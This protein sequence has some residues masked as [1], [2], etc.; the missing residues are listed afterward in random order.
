M[1]KTKICTKCGIEKELS[2][3]YRRKKSIDGLCPYCKLCIKKERS[4]YH[5]KNKNKIKL[6]NK[7]YRENN[8]EKLEEYRK[9]YYKKNRER[10][11][12]N[13]KIYNKQH[14]EERS[15]QLKIYYKNNKKKLLKKLKIYRENNKEKLFIQRKEYYNN[16]KEKVK[17][18][19]KKYRSKN[20]DKRNK[21]ARER[22]LIDIKYKIRG[23]ISNAINKKLI[24]RRSN[25]KGES[26]FTF[27]PYTLN[28]LIQHL[29]NQFESGMTWENHNVKGWHIDHIIPDCRF[30][31]K[32]VEDKEFQKCWALSNLQPLWAE[33]NLKKNK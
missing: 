12:K 7:K 19:V 6:K 4:I 14:K 15:K 20:K 5:Q 17:M 16:N 18:N 24:N 11:L 30:K 26:T 3:F 8:K 10:I 9:K 28:E 29:E 31:Y 33:E 25:K 1:G 2:E 13:K 27:L 23:R 21:R 32:N 22:R